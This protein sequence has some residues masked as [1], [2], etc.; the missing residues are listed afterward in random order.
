[1]PVA[2][3]HPTCQIIILNLT[4]TTLPLKFL[5]S[6]NA[7]H[8][9]TGLVAFKLLPGVAVAQRFVHFSTHPQAMQ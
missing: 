4:T 8:Y 6:E 7:T 2:V 5:D 3:G 1:V 9:T